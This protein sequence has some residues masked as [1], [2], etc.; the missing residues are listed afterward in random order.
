MILLSIHLSTVPLDNKS[1]RE[2]SNLRPRAPEAR[3]L[4]G[5]RYAPLR[6]K[7]SATNR[8]LQTVCYKPSAIK[9]SA[10]NRLLH[11]R[12]L[13]TVCYK[14]SATNRLLQLF[15]C[16][17]RLITAHRLLQ[18][19]CYKPSATNRLLLLQTV[20]YKPSATPSATNYDSI[21]QAIIVSRTLLFQC[22]NRLI[23]AQ[24]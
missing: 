15:Q 2:D 14:P 17:N 16:F 19:V 23:T 8:L 1:G 6:Y 3:A 22:F 18:T 11:N 21:I 12:L 5:L 10:T 20:C 13:Q 7:P 4:A 9:P 24:T